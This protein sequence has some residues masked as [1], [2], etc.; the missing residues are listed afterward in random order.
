LDGRSCE[1]LWI[2]SRWRLGLGRGFCDGFGWGFGDRLVQ[3]S[4]S[5]LFYLTV[6]AS[7]RL[8]YAVTIVVIVVVILL[9]SM[10]TV[11]FADLFG[12]LVADEVL[13][14]IAL[15]ELRALLDQFNLTVALLIN[16]TYL[17]FVLRLVIEMTVRL[18]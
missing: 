18:V 6:Y 14:F 4:A 8:T 2:R 16:M 5:C 17:E 3:V 13:H 10:D 15:K 11:D 7:A 9:I 12:N 1:R